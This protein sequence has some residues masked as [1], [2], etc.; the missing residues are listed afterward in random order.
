MQSPNLPNDY[1]ETKTIGPLTETDVQRLYSSPILSL[2][3]LPSLIPWIG[4]TAISPLPLPSRF[5]LSLL[6]P[7]LPFPFLPLLHGSVCSWWPLLGSIVFA[8]RFW[9]GAFSSLF[10][11]RWWTCLAFASWFLTLAFS[12]LL[13]VFCGVFVSRHPTESL[14][15]SLSCAPLRVLYTSACGRF[16]HVAYIVP[17]GGLH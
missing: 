15:H 13:T 3:T 6:F 2:L 4:N 14:F 9:S 8:R 1:E 11:R 7:L 12:N 16:P 17:A 5:L 10:L